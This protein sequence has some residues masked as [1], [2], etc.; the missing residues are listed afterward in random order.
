MCILVECVCV[1]GGGAIN[2]LV[3]L[4]LKLAKHYSTYHDKCTS[5][6]CKCI[7]PLCRITYSTQYETSWLGFLGQSF[8]IW[9]REFAALRNLQRMICSFTLFL[10]MFRLDFIAFRN[11]FLHINI[12][13]Y[14]KGLNV[15][16]KTKIWQ[17]KM[18]AFWLVTIRICSAICAIFI[19]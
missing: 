12:E 9:D 1:G 14:Q 7:A 16:W 19:V 11:S 6:L 18:V 15:N 4:V 2:V 3:P 17:T 10:A 13:Q 8:I 5:G